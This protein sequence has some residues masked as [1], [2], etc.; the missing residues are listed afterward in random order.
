MTA[1]ECL[2]HGF[3]DEV[4]DEITATAS[5][6]LDMLPPEARKVFDAAAN[7][8]PSVDDPAPAA[9][10]V[11]EPPAVVPP[12]VAVAPSPLADAIAAEAKAAGLESYSA[13]FVTDASATS[14]VAAQA[15]IARA[16]EVKALATHAGLA[17]KADALIRGRKSV[18]EVRAELC[19]AL[20]EAD[21]DTTVS[22]V[23][24]TK[25]KGAESAWTPTACWNH[26]KATKAG[27]V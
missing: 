5:Y 15:L 13:V 12:V 1:D 3:C 4:I 18:D 17:D 14:L 6:D 10:P 9:D 19:E 11:V 22:T 20:A 25:T 16:R 7:I 26:I 8:A 21:A 23:L 2:E 27:S 24:P